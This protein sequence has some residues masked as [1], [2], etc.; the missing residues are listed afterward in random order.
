MATIA[1]TIKPTLASLLARKFR[2]S[3]YRLV[4][5]CSLLLAIIFLVFYAW[6]LFLFIEQGGFWWESIMPPAGPHRL[7][8]LA[9]FFFGYTFYRLEQERTAYKILT[10]AKGQVIKVEN[11]LSPEAW[12]LL[13]GA[14]RYAH[15]FSHNEVQEIHL[16]AASLK[17]RSG[18]AV[19]SRLGADPDKLF[20]TLSNAL[21]KVT[22]GT[23]PQLSNSAQL[24]FVKATDLAL[25]RRSQQVEVGEIILAIAKSES[26]A[27]EVL[28]E[29]AIEPVMI[30]NIT[31][32]F[33]VRRRLRREVSRRARKAAWRPRHALDRAYLAVATPLLDQISHEL[34]YLAAHGYLKPCI[35]RDKE[36][37]EIFRIIEG[38]HSSVVLVGEPGVGKT[39]IV[40]GIAQAMVA[41]EVPEAMKDKKLI[42][43]SVPALVGGATNA[44]EVEHKLLQIMNE[45]SRA[46]NIIL[47]IDDIHNLVGQ[48]T[49]GKENLDVSEMIANFIG[50][51]GIIT[52][53]STTPSD[54]RSYLDRTSL[55]N[56]LEKVKIDEPTN[57]VVIQILEATVGQLE[58]QHKVYFSYGA[59]AQ[60]VDLSR[61]FI[62]DRFLPEK[63]IK[64]CEEAAVFVRQKNKENTTITS[65][66]I[67]QLVSGKVNVPVT[68][69]SKAEGERLLNLED[70]LHKR[71][72]GQDEAVRLVAA[73][74]RR[75][76][77]ELRT[78]SRPIATFLF[79][80]PTGVGK[81]ELAKTVAAEYFGGEN[82]MIRLDMSEYQTAESIYRLIGAPPGMGREAGYLTE[83]VRQ[84]PYALI[85]LDEFEKSHPDILNVF[86]QLFDDG[87]LTDST[88][89][90]VDFTN[91]IIIATSNAGTQFIQDSMRQG[92]TIMQIHQYL[93]QNELKQ[94]FRPELINRFDGVVVFK[95]LDFQ[96]VIA[97]TKL[98]LD[99]LARN[100]LT[101]GITLQA[102]TAAIEELAREGFDP[103]YGARPL[104][105]VIQ[106]KVD[107][108]LANYLL[109]GKLTRRD[110]VI[111]EPGGVVRIEKASKL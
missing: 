96:N 89:R 2:Q 20:N 24:I 80:G 81:T 91:A 83:A 85:L 71:I 12:Q 109:T 29:L 99:K 40:E 11:Y 47:Y 15:K 75:A 13:E 102:S 45:I 32:W 46:G 10:D 66:D 104:Q 82:K 3:M 48:S 70:I 21:T 76:R 69:V 61:R 84:A 92:K 103:L 111:L 60:A 39:A 73:A 44:N 55:G 87:R 9:V 51:S 28:D 5:G 57:D 67:A 86:L 19:F 42:Q 63:A 23:N 22:T 30:E 68:K 26:L 88:G 79:L 1:W 108:A 65:E 38:G 14:F 49:G 90:T 16:L 107:N 58:Y 18:Q 101:K 93:L 54:R 31:V 98:L 17:T 25:A 36:I 72:V 106:D 6:R 50:K 97:I 59:L 37:Q 95:P 41:E 43:L 78:A 35:G 77:V 74:L 34:T 8:W 100:L 110:V 94:Y 27:R 52:L 7:F 53:A 4:G 56:A 64:I 33:A 62:P 105:R